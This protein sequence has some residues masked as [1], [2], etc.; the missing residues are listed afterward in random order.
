MSTW[1]TDRVDARAMLARRLAAKGEA[2][3]REHYLQPADL[4]V[5]AAQGEAAKQA[6]RE[7]QVQLAELAQARTEGRDRA[8][9][10]SAREGVLSALLPAVIGDLSATTPSEA[11]FLAKLSFARYRTRVGEVPV[12]PAN[13]TERETVRRIER[14]ARG[15]R[16][17]RAQGLAALCTTLVEREP[18]SAALRARG[19]DAAF[20]EALRADAEA[21]AEVGSNK[22]VSVEA[23]ARESAAVRAQSARWSAVKHLVRRACA[24]D[25][26][27]ARLLSAC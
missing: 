13:E 24:S 7:Q 14:V 8:A 10:L 17:T 6:D 12:E 18:I 5:I 21:V 25:P 1:F 9:D 15:D 2:F 20:L 19:M 3:L 26:E 16:R 27:L 4:E 22:V 11:G 23:T